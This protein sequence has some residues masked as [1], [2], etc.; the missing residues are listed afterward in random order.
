MG[1]RPFRPTVAWHFFTQALAW[2]FPS[3]AKRPSWAPVPIP[4]GI[5]DI[6]AF[7]ALMYNLFQRFFHFTLRH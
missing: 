4:A 2:H 1:I 3:H 7:N 5:T 6:N